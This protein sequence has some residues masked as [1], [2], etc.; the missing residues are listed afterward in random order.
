[1]L[2]YDDLYDA[3]ARRMAFQNVFVHHKDGIIVLAIIRNELGANCYMPEALKPD[4]IAFDHWLL[5]QI[6]VKHKY[7]VMTETEA[8]LTA[9]N[10]NDIHEE[11]TRRN[12]RED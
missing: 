5:N 2:E 6:G 10:D 1:V 7:N 3:E 4:L 11:K 12:T 9:A 8:L